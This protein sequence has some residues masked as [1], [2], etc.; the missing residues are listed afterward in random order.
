MNPL[1]VSRS[2]S[3]LLVATLVLLAACGGEGNP[4]Q[5]PGLPGGAE[6]QGM[7]GPG[8]GAP[9]APGMGGPGMGGPG[10]GGPGMG[11]GEGLDLSRAVARLTQDQVKESGDYVTISGTVSGSTCKG[12]I[13]IDVLDGPGSQAAAGQP[14][15]PLTV[16]EVGQAGPFQLLVPKGRNIAVSAL[17]DNDGDNKI[18][19]PTDSVAFGGPVGD[20][21]KD[22]ADLKLDF[23]TAAG[24]PGMGGPGMGGPGMG[25]PGMGAPGMGA[26]GAGAAGMGGPGA[27]APGMGGPGA[28]GPGMGAPGGAPQGSPGVT[29]PGAMPSGAGAP[30]PASP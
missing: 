25:G 12:K 29:G 23:D 20:T 7:G 9:G 4:T 13:R 30:P 18:I 24:G 19:P 6:G 2:S 17:C 5:P 21:T 16:L 27:G 8:Q 26:P 1:K 11:G 14:P 10:A 3:N 28:G 22:I 15:G